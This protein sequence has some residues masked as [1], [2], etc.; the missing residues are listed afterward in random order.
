MSFKDH[1]SSV[2][3]GYAKFRPG[4]PDEL[5]DFILNHVRNRNHAWDCATGNGQA[6]IKLA[7]YF[8]K[9]TATDASSA[10][11]EN[12]APHPNV[13]Y[14]VATAENSGL[15]PQSVDLVTVAQA[16]HWFDFEKFYKEVR[17]VANEG[18][19]IA[20]WTY[21]LFYFENEEINRCL[22]E[23]YQDIVGPYW[24][25]ERAHT[26]SRY[27]SIPF[28]F[29]EIVTPEFV[30]NRDYTLVQTI[31]YLSTWSAVKN[32]RQALN[33]DPLIELSQKLSKYWSGPD[34]VLQGKT[35]IYMR[36]GKL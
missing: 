20:V 4:Y 25:P 14:T 35:P 32:F 28:P 24:P 10:Q 15:P 8:E 18:A 33:V 11:I 12:A 23:F 34:S 16:L 1:F 3:E 36:M 26:E 30:L 22:L 17:R 29:N 5:Y 6:A 2:S 7:E 27:Q 21:G 9:V 31:N 19:L 13:K